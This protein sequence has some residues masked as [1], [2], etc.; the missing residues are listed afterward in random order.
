MNNKPTWH[1][2]GA[3]SIGLLWASYLAKAGCKVVLIPKDSKHEQQLIQH[4][5]I[6]L[7]VNDTEQK[8]SFSVFN[9]LQATKIKNLLVCLKHH[10]TTKALRNIQDHT[11][12]STRIILL[13]N[14]MGNDQYLA[15]HFAHNP[16]HIASTTEAAKRL[17]INAVEHTGIGSTTFACKQNEG[18]ILKTLIDCDL[19]CNF[20]DDIDTTLWQKLIINSVINPIT[21]IADCLNG[22]TLTQVQFNQAFVKQLVNE[23]L[24][25]SSAEGIKINQAEITNSLEKVV[26]STAKNSSSM[27]EDIKHKRLTEIDGING[28]LLSIADKHKLT[29]PAH[30]QLVTRIKQLEQTYSA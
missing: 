16:Y 5:H 10:S 17:S 12:K 20:T 22:E 9:K 26:S 24:L 29:L 28:F 18:E 14:G 21:A 15:Q 7:V 25:C 3:G 23:A 27:R 13:Q 2:L 11:D 30:R 1:I 4:K 6:Q 19:S 8:L